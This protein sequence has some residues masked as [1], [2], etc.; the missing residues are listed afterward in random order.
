M[1]SAA[2]SHTRRAILAGACAAGALAPYA[3]PP[4]HAAPRLGY[5]LRILYARIGPN[6]FERIDTEEQA[7]WSSMSVRLGGLIDR[8]E[9]IQRYSML[10]NDPPAMD[11]ETGNILIARQIA[12]DA[13]LDHILL[14]SSHDGSRAYRSYSNWLS[15]AYAGLRTNLGPHDDAIAEAH[16][17]S[18]AG[19]PPVVSLSVDAPPRTRLNPF[20][21]RRNPEGQAMLWLATAVEDRIQSDARAVFAAQTSIAD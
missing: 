15:R 7:L 2:A 1:N 6:G 21:W 5:P 11:S 17:I 14:Y 12:T 4:A 18:A 20:D 13:H 3:A 19:G 8:L 16:I 10:A 9:P